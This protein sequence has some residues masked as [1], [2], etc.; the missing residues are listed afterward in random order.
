MS[1]REKCPHCGKV[2]TDLWDFDWDNDGHDGHETVET[3]C[4]HCEKP[5][6]IRRTVTVN[7]AVEIPAVKT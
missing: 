4:G 2:Q 1:D 5:I 6:V 7:Y 3:E